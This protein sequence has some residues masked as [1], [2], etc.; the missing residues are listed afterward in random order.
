MYCDFIIQGYNPEYFSF[1]FFN[2]TPETK[3]VMFLSLDF[4]R[5]INDPFAPFLL[6][7]RPLKQNLILKISGVLIL[8]HLHRITEHG[9][10]ARLLFSCVA[11]CIACNDYK[12]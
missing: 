1:Q 12:G 7:I 11:F 6:E 2:L 9:C 3:A 5:V 8:A 10:D 4:E